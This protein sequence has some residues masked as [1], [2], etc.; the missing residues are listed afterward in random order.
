MGI[1]FA[2]LSSALY[3]VNN[4]IDKFFLEKFKIAPAVITVYSGFF[5]LLV[6]A[7]VLF[8]TG[9]YTTN[10]QSILIIVASGFLTTMY[11]LPYFKALNVDETS[12]V[13]PLFQFTPVYVLLL[14]FLLLGENL[15]LKQYFG[16]ALLI[17]SSFVIS[18][19]KFDK[20]IFKIRPAL[21]Y[22]MLSSLLFA[23]STVLYKFGVEDIPFWNTLPYEGVG[24]AIGAIII[25]LFNK[26]IF[27]EQTKKFPRRVFLIMSVNEGF[28]ISSRYT[29]YF[30]L[31]LISA[32]IVNILGGIQPLFVLIYGVI[33][34][35]WFPH[36]IK[37]VITKGALGIKLASIIG[38]L[39][40]L[41]FIFL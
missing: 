3:S 28:Y 9:I 25:L 17:F 35:L 20:K 7:I 1:F 32:S 10:L 12:R 13:I 22:M 6:G 38:M 34:S 27:I 2:I 41:A 26:K 33:L 19:E 39:L 8:F 21:W 31:S 16:A 29:L 23:F 15:Q 11:V 37:E 30:A 36:I 4:Y 14:S 40:G 24:M 18:L 5:G